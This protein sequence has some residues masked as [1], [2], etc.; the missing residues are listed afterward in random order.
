MSK[1]TIPPA[2]LNLIPGIINTVASVIRDKKQENL[3]SNTELINKEVADGV[4][5]SSKRVLNVTGTGVIISFAIQQMLTHGI[6]WMNLAVMLLGVIYC[7]GLTW[8]TY[9]SEKPTID[10]GQ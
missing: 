10:Q 9:I 8:L 1:K 6:N 3:E 2:I 4:S 7:L 5:I